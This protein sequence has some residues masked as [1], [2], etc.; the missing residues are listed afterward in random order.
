MDHAAIA[1][2]CGVNGVTIEDPDDYLP[3]VKA[4]LAEPAVT[5]I[6]VATDPK[7]YPPITVFDGKLPV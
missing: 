2:A 4:A 6:D 5:L 7:A 1:R 3:A